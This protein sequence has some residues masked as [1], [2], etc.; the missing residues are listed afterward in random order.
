MKL[1]TVIAHPFRTDIDTQETRRRG[2]AEA[3]AAAAKRSL[4]PPNDDRRKF[5]SDDPCA[6]GHWSVVDCTC[7][8]FYI[9]GVLS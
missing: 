3:S 2:L 8:V 1:I 6:G 7:V 9:V 4:L 5:I